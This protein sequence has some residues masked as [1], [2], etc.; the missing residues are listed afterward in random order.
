[1][2]INPRLDIPMAV[3]KATRRRR[4]Q[5][6][7]VHEEG[8]WCFDDPWVCMSALAIVLLLGLVAAVVT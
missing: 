2:N 6:R 8:I 1:M 3:I 4:E 5:S 7:S